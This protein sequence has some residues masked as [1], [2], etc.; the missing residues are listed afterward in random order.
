MAGIGRGQL[1]VLED[2]VNARRKNFEFYVAQLQG[3]PGIGFMPDA[4]WGRHTRW[5][6]AITIDPTQFGADREAVRL[7]LEAQNIEARPV[8]KPMHQQPVFSRFERFGGEVSDDL[9]EHGLCL[10]SGSNLTAAD[11]ER[12]V[13]IIQTLPR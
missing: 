11:L 6:T 4:G 1:R 5:L 9:F 2:R 7:A 13:G 10:P 8:W 12:V 3:M